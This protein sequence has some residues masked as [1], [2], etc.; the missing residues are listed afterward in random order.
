MNI[1]RQVSYGFFLAFLLAGASISP[2]S[3]QD[4]R[5]RILAEFHPYAGGIEVPGI[6]PGMK[7]TKENAEVAK[8]VLPPE[9]LKSLQAG[10][11]EITV[12]ETVDF[13]VHP[14]YIN[15]TTEGYGKAK[16]AGWKLAG[17]EAGRPFPLLDPNGAEVGKKAAFNFRYRDRWTAFWQ[18]GW[19]EVLNPSGKADRRYEFYYIRGVGMHLPKE[20]TFYDWS[21]KGIHSKE[22]FWFTAPFDVKDQQFVQ[23]H[24]DDD[25]AEQTRYLY[26]R[27]FKRIRQVPYQAHENALNSDWIDEERQGQEGYFRD[28]DWKY[29]GETIVLAPFPVQD[30]L[31]KFAYKGKCYPDHAWQLRKAV[32]VEATP[33]VG[34]APLRRRYYL[35]LQTYTYLYEVDYDKKTG[36]HIKTSFGVWGDP[37]VQP[38]EITKKSQ[39]PI[40]LG[41]SWI[42]YRKNP[43]SCSLYGDAEQTAD[44]K[45]DETMWDETAMPDRSK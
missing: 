33:T 43:Y 22:L 19:F 11:F 3:A 39:H 25:I 26:Q 24:P 44:H 32:V 21:N 42:D 7:L 15:A 45:L 29:L 38:D 35:D 23:Y 9:I 30:V 6:K 20:L 36:E 16:V 8:E 40:L 5:E 1:G 31:S 34:D 28:Y 37:R 4:A 27:A 13:P 17:Y 14:A 12:Q 18:K 41:Q 2:A 10:D